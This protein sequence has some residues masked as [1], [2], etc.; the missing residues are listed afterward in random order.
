MNIRA[1][2]LDEA[3]THFRQLESKHH[4]KPNADSYASVI[5]AHV[6]KKYVQESEDLF[7]EMRNVRLFPTPSPSRCLNFLEQFLLFV[8]VGD[9]TV[10]RCCEGLSQDHVQFFF[11]I[12][13][14]FFLELKYSFWCFR[15]N[16]QYHHEHGN[17]L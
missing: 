2:K 7:I 5:D 9:W 14:F 6:K 4:I 15:N 12:V 13:L 17:Q 10:P 3:M 11:L 1:D 8:R 16:I